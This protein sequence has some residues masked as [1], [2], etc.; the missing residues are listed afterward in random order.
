MYYN[1]KG[2]PPKNNPRNLLS[3]NIRVFNNQNQPNSN[4]M[5]NNINNK[6]YIL[7]QNKSKPAAKE[8][9]IEGELNFSKNT[10]NNLYQNK[11]PN[12]IKQKKARNKP[13]KSPVPIPRD[14]KF[15]NYNKLFI[16]NHQSNN[17]LKPKSA[18][19]RQNHFANN[20]NNNKPNIGL[21]AFLS[22]NKTYNAFNIFKKNLE[23]KQSPFQRT[24][25]NSNSNN[26]GQIKARHVSKSPILSKGSK[27]NK[28]K[29]NMLGGINNNALANS[30]NNNKNQ[31]RKTPIKNKKPIS[32]NKENIVNNHNT[33]N[34]RS[35]VP[36]L[37]Q[38]E[39]IEEASG[40]KININQKNI[41]Y[42]NNNNEYN[43]IIPIYHSQN[44]KRE[45]NDAS[46]NIHPVNINNENVNKLNNRNELIVSNNNPQQQKI[47]NNE[48]NKEKKKIKQRSQST[49]ITDPLQKDNKEKQ[50]KIIKEKKEEN[51][52]I[53]KIK[54]ILPYTH[55]G[56]DGEEPKE[57][58]QDNYFVYKNFMNKKNYI[59]MSV[60]DGHGVE[61]HFVSDF[62]K[63]ILPYDMSENLQAFNILTENEL[64][65]EKIYDIIKQTFIEANE[66]LVNNEEINSLFS[67]STCVSVIY[68]PEKL[69]IPNIGD[70]RAVLG[71]LINKET[72]EYKAI[73]LSRDHK[74]TEKDEEKRILENDG[75]IQP[76]IEDGEFVGPQRV[77]IKE[78]EVPGLAMT[79]S[80]GDRVAATVGVVSIPEIK[81]YIFNP[82][83]K[84]MII[85][86]DGVWEFIS[87]QECIDII[88]E[89]YDK[90]DL[91]GC[92]EFLYQESSKRWLKEEEV[93]DDTTMII[94]F[95]D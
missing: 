58:N 28:Y 56:F 62:I 74:P 93:I 40:G 6:N 7:K 94:V 63:E 79:R 48:P 1:N 20:N 34:I 89:F 12:N 75:R 15:S 67:G 85:A 49:G 3:T 65:K 69:I 24:S 87:S 22:S 71:R 11:Q 5:Y 92:C 88:K 80:F 14:Y 53:K 43:N 16:N 42:I 36:K 32:N 45:N 95:F 17:S 50:N 25:I 41:N 57:N 72:N 9:I 21:N 2:N 35:K 18:I 54:E 55:V 37:I 52:C 39:L 64:E 84:F 82:N 83:D 44:I 27:F 81:E 59:Y 76:F 90:N 91:K 8:K 29:M 68:T 61:G 30:N 78:E 77:W 19:Q 86:S 66:K 23:R 38:G 73:E 10:K 60:C 51:K 47:N 13:A 26:F 31:K 70:S 4:F 46:L 33:N